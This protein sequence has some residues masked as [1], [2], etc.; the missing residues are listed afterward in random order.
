MTSD[1]AISKPV[2]ILKTP[3]N[4]APPPVPKTPCSQAIN[5][6]FMMNPATPDCSYSVNFRHPNH[7][8]M[9][10]SAMVMA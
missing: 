4:S 2:A 6:L 5:G 7:K 10:A 3:R 8:K 1:P 9:I